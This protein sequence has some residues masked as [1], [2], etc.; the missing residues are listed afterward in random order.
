MFST[1][2]TGPAGDIAARD[3]C[4]VTAADPDDEAV[5]QCRDRHPYDRHTHSE[6]APVLV[7]ALAGGND[8][9]FGRAA[10]AWQGQATRGET[11]G[12][13]HP[14]RPRAG[15]EA[16]LAYHSHQCAWLRPRLR[17]AWV[18]PLWALPP[19]HFQPIPFDT[20]PTP[21]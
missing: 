5:F 9:A 1:G 8:N 10:T 21:P 3:I 7:A 15:V 12:Q 4:V 2:Q 13:S 6:L 11:D 20:G 14:W 18:L 16:R 19:S 17:G